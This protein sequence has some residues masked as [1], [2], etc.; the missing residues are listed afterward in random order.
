[1]FTIIGGGYSGLEPAAV[2]SKPDKKVVLLKGLDGGLA[3]M[4]RIDLTDGKA[5]AM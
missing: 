2:M 5:T 3:R 1:M 4:D